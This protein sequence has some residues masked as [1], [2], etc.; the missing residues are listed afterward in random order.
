M[1]GEQIELVEMQRA[2]SVIV[3]QPVI[4]YG[5]KV[6]CLYFERKDEQLLDVK[7]LQTKL[8][9]LK[10]DSRYKI[11]KEPQRLL[12]KRPHA[13]QGEDIDMTQMV[14]WTRI[15]ESDDNSITEAAREVGITLDDDAS[16]YDNIANMVVANQGQ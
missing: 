13:I 10:L 3:N 16:K 4:I 9:E 14:P 12:P 8:Q 7:S 6:D 15:L 2:L 1:N 5:A 11:T